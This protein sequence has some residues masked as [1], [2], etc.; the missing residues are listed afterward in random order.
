MQSVAHLAKAIRSLSDVSCLPAITN[1]DPITKVRYRLRLRYQVD[2]R[3]NWLW[4]L[5][6]LRYLILDWYTTQSAIET[7]YGKLPGVWLRY[8]KHYFYSTLFQAEIDKICRTMT[9]FM[10]RIKAQIP[11]NGVRY[12]GST[13]G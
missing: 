8:F 10:G 1:D 7:I 12:S 4:Y 9:E 13:V 11:S 6:G 3:I 2:Y 5:T